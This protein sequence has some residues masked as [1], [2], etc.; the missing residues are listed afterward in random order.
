MLVL[1]NMICF[2][3][4]VPDV[5]SRYTIGFFCVFIVGLHLVFNLFLILFTN[6]KKLKFDI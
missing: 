1:Y 2:S 4:F 3:N 5:N 6:F